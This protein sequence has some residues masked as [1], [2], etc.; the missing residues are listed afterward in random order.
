MSNDLFSITGGNKAPKADAAPVL[1]YAAQVASPV[2]SGEAKLTIGEDGLHITALFDA[3][4]LPYA[5]MTRLSHANWAITIDTRAENYTLSRMGNWCEPFFDAL[6]TAYNKKVVKA[7]F[8]PGE[9]VLKTKG[10]CVYSES[11]KPTQVFAPIHVYDNC[12]A[13]FPPDCNAR[14]I[15]LCFLTGMDRGSYTLTL[16]LGAE[17]LY[18]FQKLGYDTE[19]FAGAIEKQIRLLRERSLATIRELDP[20]LTSAQSS[21]IAKLMPEGVAA[22]M[23]RLS[24]IAPSFVSAVEASLDS[25]RASATYKAFQKLCDPAQIWV[26]IKKKNG[27]SDDAQTVG[28]GSGAGVPDGLAAG[29][30]IPGA[31][32]VLLEG[33]SEGAADMSGT[34][35]MLWL[36]AP[37]PDGSSCAVEFVGDAGDAAATFVYRLGGDFDHFASKLNR[38]LEAIDFRRE[39]I[40]LTDEELMKPA[41]QDYRM[42][43]ERNPALQFVRSRF[44]GRVIHSGSW[45]AN[46]QRLWL[47]Q[48]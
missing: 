31:M 25:S 48:Q 34:S 3:V 39:P 36:I 13:V 33:G 20:A 24:A 17:D 30:A 12:V 32:Q 2:L 9:P 19:P 10:V 7:L 35:H 47:S 43:V 44:V 14:R 4:E 42:A 45:E 23:G 38:A 40:R 11:G 28:E 29:A 21:A 15:P 16:R 41:Y 18:A 1:E 26:G 6:L 5:D 22:Q 8:L 37:S 27:A 46:L